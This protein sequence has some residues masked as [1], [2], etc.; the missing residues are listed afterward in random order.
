MTEEEALRE[1]K[2][3]RASIEK[4]KIHNGPSHL[5]MQQLFSLFSKNTTCQKDR[6]SHCVPKTV[7][8][9][10]WI[11]EAINFQ[12]Y[13][14]QKDVPVNRAQLMATHNSFNTRADGCGLEDNL[15]RKLLRYFSDDL[16]IVIAQQEFSMYDQ[17]SFGVKVIMLDPH[18]L[19]GKMRMC[20]GGNHFEWVDKLIEIVKKVFHVDLEL[21]SEQLGCV[22]D[23]RLWDD[24]ISEISQWLNDH[25]KEAV[26]IMINDNPSWDHEK[27]NL[28][29]DPMVKHFKD[30]IFLTSDVKPG[31][32]FPSMRQLV[33]MNK[34]VVIT[35]ANT[36]SM[37]GGQFIHPSFVQNGYPHNTLKLFSEYPRCGGYSYDHV[38]NFGGESCIFSIFYNGPEDMGLLTP[39]ITDNQGLYNLQQ[40]LDC[41]VNHIS[42]DQS[43]PEL[44]ALG[45]WTWARNHPINPQ[46]NQCTLLDNSANRWVSSLCDVQESHSFVCRVNNSFVLTSRTSSKFEDGPS[47]CRQLNGT[48]SVPITSKESRMLSD[49]INKSSLYTWINLRYT[50]QTFVF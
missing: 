36:Y 50:N 49:L 30:L 8:Y 12:T 34:R 3:I 48:F 32:H 1:Y 39:S 16:D 20:H 18:Y 28:V 47:Y 7:Q 24:G 9:D 27:N 17:M 38:V 35:A 43:S 5:G 15:L 45:V 14:L 29:L 22:P 40:L 26:V 21:H 25:P 44:A 33:E 37:F 23:S 2:R 31:N 11:P 4:Y 6:L 10:K 46:V 13:I 19:D 42:M 41:G